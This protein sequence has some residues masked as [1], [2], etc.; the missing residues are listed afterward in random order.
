MFE[1][2]GLRKELKARVDE[3]L[4]A[5]NEWSK[6]ARELTEALNRLTDSI[7]NG[8]PNKADIKSIARTSKKLA[9]ETGRLTRAFE[10]EGT[11]LEKILNK[12]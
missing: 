10:A 2:L 1:L 9:R 3:I 12:V 5:G 11:I 6:T 4:N 7:K 8:N